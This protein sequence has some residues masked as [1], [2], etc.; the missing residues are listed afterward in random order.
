MD[1]DLPFH[2]PLLPFL[3]VLVFRCII[4]VWFQ[5]RR[6]KWRKRENTKKGPGRPAHNAHPQTCSGEPIPP[7]ELERREKERLEKKRRK[8]EQ[9]IRRLEARNSCINASTRDSSLDSYYS[10]SGEARKSSEDE[11]VDVIGDG[12]ASNNQPPTGVGRNQGIDDEDEDDDQ[13]AKNEERSHHRS[14]CA[15]DYAAECDNTAAFQAVGGPSADSGSGDDAGPTRMP[16]SYR[17]CFSFCAQ[18][19]VSG[20]RSLWSDGRCV[21]GIQR[22]STNVDSSNCSLKEHFGSKDDAKIGAEDDNETCR[23]MFDYSNAK[24]SSKSPKYSSYNRCNS[25][26]IWRILEE[27]TSTSSGWQSTAG[28]EFASGGTASVGLERPTSFDQ[29]IGFQVERISS[30]M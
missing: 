18:P 24:V 13:R 29:P 19:E 16:T 4:Q 23:L 28:K 20:V 22:S 1:V 10:V 30:P 9:R 17:P 14:C 12:T 27:P 3:N 21:G 25:F 11:T 7:E 2:F 15:H 5:N 6:A 26:S 8:Q